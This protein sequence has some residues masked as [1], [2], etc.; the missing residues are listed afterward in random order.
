[1]N[2]TPSPFDEREYSPATSQRL[3]EWNPGG[4]RD[5]SEALY[6]TGK[7][8]FFIFAQFGMI[9]RHRR[10]QGEGGWFGV[11]EIRPVTIEEALAWCEETGNYEVIDE[12][13]STHG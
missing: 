4:L 2:A 13:F 7:G 8:N 3:A 1:M 10:L 9:S 12:H 11:S 6:K 5:E